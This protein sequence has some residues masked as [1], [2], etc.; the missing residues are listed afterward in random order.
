MRREGEINGKKPRTRGGQSQ[1]K[2]NFNKKERYR[3]R[4]KERDMGHQMEMSIC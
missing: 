3:K 4:Q 2:V 1:Q